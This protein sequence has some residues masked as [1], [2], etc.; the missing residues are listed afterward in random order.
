M[1]EYYGTRRSGISWLPV[2][3][4][5]FLAVILGS[6]TYYYYHRGA[7]LQQQYERLKGRPARPAQGL[8]KLE[9]ENRELQSAI[10]TQEVILTEFSR[11]AGQSDL[12]ALR[13]YTK[14]IGIPKYPDLTETNLQL[15]RIVEGMQDDDKQDIQDLTARMQTLSRAMQ[16]AI[17]KL[18]ETGE[19]TVGDLPQHLPTIRDRVRFLI[20]QA[21][22]WKEL[23][24][25]LRNTQARLDNRVKVAQGELT[26]TQR[27][28]RDSLDRFGRLK[29][30][31]EDRL[32]SVKRFYDAELRKLESDRKAVVDQ[33]NDEKDRQSI[34]RADI[35]K[36]RLALE[37]K[38]RQYEKVFKKPQYFVHEPD[39]ELVAVDIRQRRAT[40]DV[41]SRQ[42]VVRGMRFLVYRPGHYSQAIKEVGNVEVTRVGLQSSQCTLTSFDRNDPPVAGD[43]VE[44]P[45]L[46][47]NRKR[48]VRFVVEGPFPMLP[49]TA[50]ETREIIRRWGG[51]IDEEIDYSTDYL[52][53]DSAAIDMIEKARV[54]NV[55]IIPPEEF[56]KFIGR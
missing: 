22:R 27:K 13:S 5:A 32:A 15:N 28:F 4:F 41:G 29:A 14:G 23:Q 2:I 39:G 3:V 7:V 56:V 31:A 40:I 43:L 36:K 21:R 35:L 45:I 52:I 50:D 8:S 25:D 46:K 11:L 48:P 1:T 16:Q 38:R 26:E 54:L 37:E 24:Q 51:K 9:G 30:E 34:Q 33:I 49:Y 17:A 44:N 19:I 10:R 18:D 6:T 55:I 42:G 20:E 53:A 12:G 47:G